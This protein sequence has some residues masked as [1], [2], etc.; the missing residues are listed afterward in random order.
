[1]PS[2]TGTLR[3]VLRYGRTVR[4]VYR[5]GV[6]HA[7]VEGAAQALVVLD[8]RIAWIG[9]DDDAPTDGVDQVV[10]LDGAL[11][12][13]GFVDAHAHVLETGFALT[14]IDLSGSPSLAA[15]LDAVAR[16]ARAARAARNV[17]EAR[18]AVP[19]SAELKAV[20]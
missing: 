14:G 7:R 15:V 3:T 17:D 12:T 11:V 18:A 13:P 20:G 6:V 8:G 19:S 9:S 16:A 4:T 10:G 5:D 2:R 1:M